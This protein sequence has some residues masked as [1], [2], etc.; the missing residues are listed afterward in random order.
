MQKAE[1]L[2]L[3]GQIA[4][5]MPRPVVGTE[6]TLDGNRSSAKNNAPATACIPVKKWMELFT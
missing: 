1:R 4:T 2:L 6:R 3:L 5:P